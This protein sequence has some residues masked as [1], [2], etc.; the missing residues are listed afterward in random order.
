MMDDAELLR[1]Y[2]AEGSEAAFAELVQ[3]HL[4]LVYRAALRQLGGDAH[5][6]EDVAQLVF[7]LLA[8]K[9]AALAHHPSLAGWLYTTTHLTVGETLRAERRRQRREQEAQIMHEL[10]SDTGSA[11]DWD[12]LRPIL[13][14]VMQDLNEADREAILLRFFEERPFG[15]IGT[16]LALSEDAARM[17]VERALDKLHG[18][19]ARRGF[20]STSVMLAAM[21]TTEAAIA[22]PVGLSATVTGAA[23][24]GV[25]VPL[26]TGGASALVLKSFYLMS[27]AKI[28]A[29]AVVVA[30]LAAG[31]AFFQ[32]A[33]AR[34]TR[35]QLTAA[36]GEETDLTVKVADLQ[37]RLTAAEQRV[38]AVDGGS[39][40]LLRTA[41]NTVAADAEAAQ[42]I[43]VDGVQARYQQ[44][45]ALAKSGQFAAALKEFLWC[46][47]V[48]MRQIASFAGVRGSSL[49]DAIKALGAQYPE[50]LTALRTR[51]DQA[52]QRILAGEDD[53]RT[54]A[55]F[56]SLNRILDQD[57]RTLELFDQLPAN[58]GRRRTMAIYAFNN[59]VAA[60]RYADA[61]LAQSYAMMS[62][63]FE[64]S[65]DRANQATGPDPERQQKANHD[66]LVETTVR[67]VEV[68]AGSG[69]LAHARELA[70]R[71]L[72]YDGSEET[73]GTLRN[74]LQRAG[75]PELLANPSQP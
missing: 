44:A 54:I 19:L 33:E 5:R 6:A 74:H 28:T 21:L 29:V 14:V 75:H 35:A 62:S 1:Q 56:T 31:T 22:A 55:D 25:S 42:P 71:L 60:Q 10:I 23:L 61:G 37:R 72:A 70:G 17:R 52:D 38:V 43:T 63:H 30:L 49:P 39:A 32:L 73:K 9:A 13:D 66:Y 53:S 65:Q 58:D 36:A 26:V 11:T 68:L 7:T 12:R 50:A 41:Q 51:R 15:E 2:A 57:E 67:D 18:L 27:S 64:L 40:A 20:S 47:D 16:K 46:Y 8:R 59:L 24:A 69:D 45:Q 3:R 34:T 48:G 4:N